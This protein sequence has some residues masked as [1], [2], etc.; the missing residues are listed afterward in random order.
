M[1]TEN[2]NVLVDNDLISLD[3]LSLNNSKT[4][5]PLNFLEQKVEHDILNLFN[6]K[7]DKY[8]SADVRL[9]D[10]KDNLKLYHYVY[11]DDDSSDEIKS[12]RGIVRDKNTD[13]I[14]CKTFGY[15]PEY[16]LF[17]D[18]EKINKSFENINLND[19]I[20]F[21]AE[22]GATI[23]VF[24][25]QNKWYMS[26]HKKLDAFYSKWGTVKTKSFGEMFVDALDWEY[27]NGEWGNYYND[28]K[29]SN[30]DKEVPELTNTF[31][32][33]CTLLN[34]NKVYTFLVRNIETNRIV[35]KTDDHP[36]VYFIGSFD[37]ERSLLNENNWILNQ[38]G[39][40]KDNETMIN[41]PKIIEGLDTIDK[42][43]KHVE[44]MN[45]NK[46]QGVIIYT[47]NNNH[48]FKILNPKYSDYFRARGNE[49][50][51]KFRYL[52]VRNDEEM[53]RLLFEL[54]PDQIPVFEKYEKIIM[55]LAKKIYNSYV[56]RYIIRNQYVVLPQTEYYIMRECHN[57][58]L[59]NKKQNRITINHVLREITNQEITK[60]N[61]M[62]KLYINK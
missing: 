21:E 4:L 23:R 3:Q 55:E 43:L 28:N 53:V 1:T 29:K 56:T 38:K 34:K 24:Y 6:F 39:L 17:E 41:T 9:T 18:D 48:Q 16:T 51:I 12:Y 45:Y 14:V 46:K 61:R 22:E 13:E 54:Y 49:P 31:E 10:S 36:Q 58:H 27:E 11:C 19:C 40:L 25:Y 47:P 20:V 57:W 50:S 42:V 30:E 59:Q 7:P 5:N 33:Y 35:C 60:L 37:R 62:I 32:K 26:T 2:K 52:Q 15:T 8:I 44:Y